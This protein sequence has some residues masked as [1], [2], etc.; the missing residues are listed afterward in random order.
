M[1]INKVS[2]VA[3]MNRVAEDVGENEDWLFDVATKCTPKTAWY[4]ST[5]LARMA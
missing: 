5:E 1:H 3:T 2:H 4:G